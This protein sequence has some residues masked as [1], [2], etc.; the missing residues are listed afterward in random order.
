MH[1][2]TLCI[3]GTRPEA[4]KM[5][6]VI[7]ELNTNPLFNN[8]I[9]VTGQHLQL[10]DTVLDLFKITPDFNLHV[11][12]AKQDLSDLTAKILTGL[13]PIFEQ[14][15]P[16][17]VLVHGDT[18]TT[19]A[20]SIA[21]YYHHVP[22]AHVEAGLRTGDINLPWPEEANRKFLKEKKELFIFINEFF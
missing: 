14:Y 8:K 4:I 5:A 3:F 17:L 2:N 16:M 1:V 9:C 18:T 6:P 15:K 13:K 19:L 11:M 22:I 20:A 21:A 12:T 7:R 10:L